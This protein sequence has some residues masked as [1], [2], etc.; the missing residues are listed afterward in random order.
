MV[1]AVEMLAARETG[2]YERLFGL[3]WQLLPEVLFAG[4]SFFVLFFVLSYL[5]FNP[6]RDMLKKR[7]EKIK[8]DL[9]TAEADKKEAK[10][11]K[12]FY[13]EKRRHA[14]REA[15]EVLRDAGKRASKL[16]ADRI[17]LANEEAEQIRKRASGEIELEKKRAMNDMRNEIIAIAAQMA[18]KA[19]SANMT[20]SLQDALIK[21]TLKEMGE[22]TWQ[23]R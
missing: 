8:T 11:L 18:G 15:E 14:D 21:E 2:S 19:V 13:E 17:R 6:V 5:L 4:V 12:A 20:E 16:E 1:Q 7:Q 22:E 23:S 3:D 10:R 9:D